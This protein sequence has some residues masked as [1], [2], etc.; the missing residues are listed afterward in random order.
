MAKDTRVRGLQKHSLLDLVLMNE[1]N[2]VKDVEHL[3]PLGKSDNSIIA[4]KY[5]TYIKKEHKND[6]KAIRQGE[7][8]RHEK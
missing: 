1:E 4:F 2:M 7:L 8:H 5:I 3:S 6:K